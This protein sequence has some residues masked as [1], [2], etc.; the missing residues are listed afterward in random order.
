MDEVDINISAL[1]PNKRQFRILTEVFLPKDAQ[2]KAKFQEGIE[3]LF[4][5]KDVITQSLYDLYVS[6]TLYI[7]SGIFS[8]R[9][10]VN[11]FVA[12]FIQP[13]SKIHFADLWNFKKK[14]MTLEYDLTKD[15]LLA[16]V[17]KKY[18]KPENRKISFDYVSYIPK[19]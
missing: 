13:K 19:A 9:Q 18:L 12:E 16:K 10:L 7:T 2:I 3:L 5:S 11:A 4:K 15:A 14:S 1:D 8:D 17:A 6:K